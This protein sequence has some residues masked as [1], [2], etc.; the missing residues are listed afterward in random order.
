MKKID[1]FTNKYSISKTLR[2]RLIP[3][4]KTLEYFNERYLD[5]DVERADEYQIVKE[6]IDRYHKTFIEKTL[7][8]VSFD[9]VLIQRYEELYKNKNRSDDEDKEFELVKDSLRKTISSIFKSKDYSDEYKKMHGK[10]MFSE[11]L[12]NILNKDELEISNHF[13]KFTT[14]F[15]GFNNNRE[16]IYSSDNKPSSI[17]YRCIDENL[18]KYINNALIYEKIRSTF[19]SND[20][21]ELDNGIK[22][23]NV[24]LNL[25]SNINNFNLVLSQKGID[26]YNKLLGGYIDDNG[27]KIQGLNELINLYNQK[28]EKNKRIPLLLQ[29]YKQILSDRDTIFISEFK[30]DKELINT[31]KDNNIIINNAVDELEVLNNNID[32]YYNEIALSTTYVSNI[33]N[34]LYGSWDYIINKVIDKYLLENNKS[35]KQTDTLVDEAKK[36]FNSKKVHS[37][38]YLDSICDNQEKATLNLISKEISE[39]IADVKTKY[40]DFLSYNLDKKL[41]TDDEYIKL[42]KDYLDSVKELESIIKNIGIK[43]IDTLLDLEFYNELLPIYDNIVSIDHI[44]NMVRNYVTKKPYSSDKIKL[45]FDNPQLL[46][47]WDKNKERDYRSVI[48]LDSNQYYLAIMDKSNTK[49]FLDYPSDGVCYKKMVYK[50][51]PGP[52]KMLPKVFFADGNRDIFTPSKEIDRIYS[53]GSFKKGKTFNQEELWELID[54]YKESINKH[55]DWSKFEFIFKNSK[56]YKDIA[57]FYNDISN[58]GYNIS[59]SN[60]S[61]EYVN[62]LVDKGELY[63]FKLYNKDFSEYSKGKPNLHTMYFKMLFDSNNLNDVV[64]KLNGECEMFYR[65]ASIKPNITHPKGQP[66][67]N[68]NPNNKKDKSV[69]D[70][71]LIKD[72]RYS[73]NQFFLHLPITMNYKEKSN[74]STI[75]NDVKKAIV[76]SNNYII[77]IDRGERN[78]IYICVIDDK[79]KIVEQESLNSIIAN[80]NEVNYQELLDNKEKERD[81]ARK[82]WKTIGN[83]KEIKEGYLSQVVHKIC[84]Y[85]V[86]YDAII[87]LE[88]LNSGFKNS[89]IKIEKQVYE[90]FETM[91]VDKLSYLVFKDKDINEYGGLLKAY[92][93]ASKD[94]KTN[95]IQNGI[96]FHIPAWNTSKIDPVTGFTNLFTN[97]K[98]KSIQDTREF[99][100]NIDDIRYNINEDLFEFDIRYSNF[101]V[102]V[103]DP[104][105]RWTLC[106]Y[107]NRIMTFRNK[108]KNSQWDNKEIELTKEFKSLLNQYGIINFNDLK[109]QM[110]KIEEKDFYVGFIYLF[111]LMLQLRNSITGNVDVDY[112]ISP[113]RNSNGIFFDSR[114]SNDNLPKDAD[115]NGAYNIARKLLMIVNK[116]KSS[117]IIEKESLTITNP[118]WLE[119]AQNE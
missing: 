68:K 82:D 43:A 70:Y 25:L 32:N 22:K 36:A 18:P 98:Y 51:L 72:K 44:Y 85:V 59:F 47:G 17:A 41:S 29:L 94:I 110:L 34:K 50:L 8:N 74:Y 40:N 60:I 78:L 100:N 107:G 112:I 37:I 58:Q 39:K 116:L 108:E 87:S 84:E 6:Y 88:N 49:I 53:S 52:N 114:N 42:I 92:Q 117:D 14:Y 80:N 77:G 66:I 75:N 119:F 95:Q 27:N 83:I 90:K 63:L 71:D 16:N 21:K 23:I 103:N 113:V 104:K 26:T 102:S 56:D 45:N 76:D 69:F 20:L 5:T 35:K 33:S 89:R 54:F 101:K 105:D 55:E 13:S 57:E 28:Q 15:V 81:N 99:I 67:V 64:Y 96:I 2:F 109:S 31:L 118:E 48:L 106:S 24:D 93:L 111:K 79:G 3:Q 73:E 115:A 38:S 1:K 61:K 91:L 10:E 86:K 9:N 12:P 65:K 97:L 30:D 19:E 4:G 11:L 46:G 62:N 7:S